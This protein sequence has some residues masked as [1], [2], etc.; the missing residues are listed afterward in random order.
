MRQLGVSGSPEKEV[1]AAAAAAAAAA[2]RPGERE[3]EGPLLRRR[4]YDGLQ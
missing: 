2:R 1:P 4:E 3:K